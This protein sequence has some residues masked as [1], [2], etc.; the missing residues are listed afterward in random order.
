MNYHERPPHENTGKA[1]DDYDEQLSEVRAG[2]TSADALELLK[3]LYLKLERLW[4]VRGE[5]KS[6]KWRDVAASVDHDLRDGAIILGER[7]MI[8][9]NIGK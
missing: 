4:V 7:G 9:E 3:K 6:E 2:N 5:G 1:I 8:D